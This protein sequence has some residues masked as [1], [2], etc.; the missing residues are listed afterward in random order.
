MEVQFSSSQSC[1][2]LGQLHLTSPFNF[3]NNSDARRSLGAPSC[4][5]QTLHR[6]SRSHRKVSLR[7]VYECSHSHEPGRT[8]YEL[9]WVETPVSGV[10][11]VGSVQL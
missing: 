10:V 9:L 4:L 11:E 7:R 1:S 5:I 2:P 6:S 8:L 3:H